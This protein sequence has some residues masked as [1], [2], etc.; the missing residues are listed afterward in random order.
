MRWW[1]DGQLLPGEKTGM[2]KKLRWHF[3]ENGVEKQPS[4]SNRVYTAFTFVHSGQPFLMKVD[5]DGRLERWDKQVMSRLRFGSVR[6]KVRDNQAVTL[7]DFVDYSKFQRRLD[8]IARGLPRAMEMK[9]FEEIPPV[10]PNPVTGTTFHSV[11]TPSS[12]HENQA[13]ASVTASTE[14]ASSEDPELVGHSSS[15]NRHRLPEGTTHQRSPP[16]NRDSRTAPTIQD[17]AQM[18]RAL[19]DPAHSETSTQENLPW[20]S[21]EATVVDSKEEML[22]SKE[23]M[24]D[25]KEERLDSKEERLDSKQEREKAQQPSKQGV[26]PTGLLDDTD[27]QAVARIL[28]IPAVLSFLRVLVNLMNLLGCRSPALW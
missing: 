11:S 26:A 13:Q 28:Q 27:P 9:N 5:V 16:W 20:A 7:V 24:L 22:D 25:S 19:S 6:N 3:I 23:E 15:A 8:E 2:Y 12:P 14:E 18:M 17:L 1:F 4:H 21:D 10:V